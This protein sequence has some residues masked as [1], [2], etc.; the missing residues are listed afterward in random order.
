[1]EFFEVQKEQ[2]KQAENLIKSD[3][4]FTNE[5]FLK[6]DISKDFIND[7]IKGGVLEEVY[8]GVYI[9]TNSYVDDFWYVR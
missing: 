2:L 8:Y 7:L 3:I 9:R 1:M 4:I 5:D 6:K